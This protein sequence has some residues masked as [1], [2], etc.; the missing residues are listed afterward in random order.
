MFCLYLVDKSQ[1]SS[2]PISSKY[3]IANSL[4]FWQEIHVMGGK[5]NTNYFH[6]QANTFQH[7]KLEAE[8]K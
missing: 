8:V 2:E 4:S 3:H 6:T 1:T 5:K 7:T